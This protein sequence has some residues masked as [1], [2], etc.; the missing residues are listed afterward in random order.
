MSFLD[1]QEGAHPRQ[2]WPTRRELASAAYEYIAPSCNRKC[3]H[4]N[5]R[6]APT[7][8]LRGASR[9]ST[10]DGTVPQERQARRVV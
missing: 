4:F 8:R 1:A 2:S 5:T 7:R 9:R 3:P 10:D 6:D